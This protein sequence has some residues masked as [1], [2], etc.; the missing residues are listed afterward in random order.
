MYGIPY[1]MA[2]PEGPKSGWRCRPAPPIDVIQALLLGCTG[3]LETSACHALFAGKTGHVEDGGAIAIAPSPGR[4]PAKRAAR[5]RSGRASRMA[6]VS[7]GARDVPM[8]RR[9]FSLHRWR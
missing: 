6:A 7:A 4:I 3:R 5:T 8:G 9:A 1:G 2:S